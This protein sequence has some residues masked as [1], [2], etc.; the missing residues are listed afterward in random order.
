M[1]LIIYKKK[2]NI[3][4]LKFRLFKQKQNVKSPASVFVYFYLFASYF[5]KLSPLTSTPNDLRKV[6]EM[7]YYAHDLNTEH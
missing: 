1:T 4:I 5:C 3:I 2:I 7:P 6:L